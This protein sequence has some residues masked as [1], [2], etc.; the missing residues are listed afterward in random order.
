MNHACHVISIIIIIIIFFCSGGGGSGFGGQLT[1]VSDCS[2]LTVPVTS[3][4]A[5]YITH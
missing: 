4:R 2:K 1:T 3:Q 5:S